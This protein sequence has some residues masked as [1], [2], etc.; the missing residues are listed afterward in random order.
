[1]IRRMVRRTGTYVIQR[2]GLCPEGYQTSA[3]NYQTT[4]RYTSCRTPGTMEN[5]GIGYMKLLVAWHYHAG[6]KLCIR[7]RSMP[8]NE[9]FSRKA[10]RKA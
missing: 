3:R 1:M 2:Q 10:S 6:Q 9:I 4:L 7:M 5:I 8:T